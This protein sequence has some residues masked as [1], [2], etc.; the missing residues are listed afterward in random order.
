MSA[1]PAAPPFLVVAAGASG[2]ADP[3]RRDALVATAG[4]AIEA[5]TGAAPEVRITSTAAAGRAAAREAVAAG[6]RLLAAALGIPRSPER[7]AVAL[8]TAREWPIDLGRAWVG[9]QADIPTPFMVAAG[10]GFDARVMA[11]TTERR[12][13]SLGIG[14]YFAAATAVAARTRPFQVGLAVDGVVHETDALAVLVANA[15]ELIPGLLRPRLPLVPDDGLLDVLVAR[16][17]GLVGGS[18]AAVELLIGRGVHTAIGPYAARMA[19]RHVEVDAPAGEPVEVDGDV[20]GAG[21]WSPR[22]SPAPSGS[23]FRPEGRRGGR[24]RHGTIGA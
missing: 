11:A 22:W 6:A 12:K 8:A 9:T 2:L 4:A 3:V 1:R 23:S 21:R 7:A 18:R 19:G 17:R 15:G 16:G 5:R 20:V 14:A 13:R 24:P 10:I